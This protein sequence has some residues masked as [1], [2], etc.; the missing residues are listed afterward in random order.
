MVHEPSD[1]TG[2]EQQINDIIAAYL[3]AV[4]AGKAPTGRNCWPVIPSWRPSCRRSSP[5]T[6]AFSRWPS[7]CAGPGRFTGNPGRW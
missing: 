2:R 3:Q 1:S 5:T 4:D 6:T 7:R